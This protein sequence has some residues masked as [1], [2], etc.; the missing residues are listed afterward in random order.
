MALFLRGERRRLCHYLNDFGRPSG[1]SVSA[2]DFLYNLPVRQKSL[3]SPAL[4][5]DDCRRAVEALSLSRPEVSFTLTDDGSGERILETEGGQGRTRRQAFCDLFGRQWATALRTI[6]ETEE[7]RSLHGFVASEAFSNKTRQFLLVNGVHI[8]GGELLKAVRGCL[9]RS[10]MCRPPPKQFRR[11]ENS[12]NES[13]SKGARLCP[14]FC[15][16]LR[17]PNRECDFLPDPK[18]TS[19]EFSDW[20]EANSFVQRGLNAFLKQNSLLPPDILKQMEEDEEG[21]KE[22]Q[23]PQPQS[24]LEVSGIVPLPLPILN[25]NDSGSDNNDDSLGCEPLQDLDSESDAKE[26]EPANFK[27]SDYFVNVRDARVS[28]V[29]KRRHEPRS[30]NLENLKRFR[31]EDVRTRDAQVPDGWIEKTGRDG[32]TYYVQMSTGITV[33]Q[34]SKCGKAPLSQTSKVTAKN[35]KILSILPAGK[36]PFLP[37]IKRKSR[38]VA[39]KD[40][41]SYVHSKWRDESKQKQDLDAGTDRKTASDI[42]SSWQNPVF[43]VES[44]VTDL[45]SKRSGISLGRHAF[46]FDKSMFG[47]LEVVGQVDRKFIAAKIKVKETDDNEDELLILFDQH[48]VHERI[49][50]ESLIEG[51]A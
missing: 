32:E 17:W 30:C 23:L 16:E 35:K 44:E 34:A 26:V 49:R 10:V 12:A 46:K 13:P 25:H 39:S 21:G 15:L 41:E 37:D 4:E 19:V 11:N 47:S 22:I 31:C 48:A 8:T 43:K 5:L 3:R 50:L 1:A 24:L 9:K 33:S 20:R 14:V 45:T 36:T 27:C 51:E 38:I 18:K 2:L 40:A 29:V 42:V 7:G 28:K 6:N